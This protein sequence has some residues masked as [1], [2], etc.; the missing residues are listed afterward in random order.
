VKCSGAVPA[1]IP[2]PMQVDLSTSIIQ[3]T[4]PPSPE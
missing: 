4:K 2:E 1:Q 3:V